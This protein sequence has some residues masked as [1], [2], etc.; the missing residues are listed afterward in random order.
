MGRENNMSGWSPC[1]CKGTRK[2]R[3]K[4]WRVYHRNHNHSY[5]E[6]PKGEEHYSDY[7]AVGCLKCTGFFRTKADYVF[8][9]K[10]HKSGEKE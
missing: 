3:M 9:L 2:E 7:S 5:F 10:D 6:S 8:G 1:T 4:N